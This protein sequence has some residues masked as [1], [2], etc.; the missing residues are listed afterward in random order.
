MHGITKPVE[1]DATLNGWAVTMS[2]KNTAGFTLKGKLH[3]SDFNV[4]GSSLTTGVG[5][6]IMVWTNI[7]MGKN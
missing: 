5:D 6:D 7:E 2:K 1:F 4:G 3:R